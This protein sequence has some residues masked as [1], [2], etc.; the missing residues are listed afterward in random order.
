MSEIDIGDIL[1]CSGESKL[2]KRI[3]WFNRVC[4]V[5]GMAAE[6]THGAEGAFNQQVFES[7]TLNEW[8]D[9]SGVQLNPFDEWLEH[10]NGRVWIRRRTIHLAPVN[11]RVRIWAKQKQLVGTPYEHGIPGYWELALCIPRWNIWNKTGYI[12][13]TQAIVEADKDAGLC[14]MYVNSSN[15]PPWTLWHGGPYDAALTGNELGL[16]EQLK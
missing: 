13:C 15:M 10:Y 14:D 12:H 9:K 8:C 7:T 11:R 5:K 2:S 1:L 16:A 3:K 4:G 6:I